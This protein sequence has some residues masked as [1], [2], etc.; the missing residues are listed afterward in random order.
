ML[1]S[2]KHVRFSWNVLRSAHCQLRRRYNTGLL[3]NTTCLPDKVH[4]LL[5]RDQWALGM[6]LRAQTL[7]TSLL[8]IYVQIQENIEKST[9]MR[10]EE[11]TT[12]ETTDIRQVPGSTYG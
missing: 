1:R 11:K 4:F 10:I 2:I 9:I 8:I 6:R 3:R 7:L 12:R 5:T